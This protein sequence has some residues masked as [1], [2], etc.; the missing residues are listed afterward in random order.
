MTDYIPS[1]RFKM[2][3]TKIEDFGKKPGGRGEG[4]SPFNDII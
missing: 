3:S 1:K 4:F 2:L